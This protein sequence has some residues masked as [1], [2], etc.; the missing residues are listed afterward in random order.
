[1]KNISRWTA[2]VLARQ[3]YSDVQGAAAE[4]GA[5]REALAQAAEDQIADQNQEVGRDPRALPAGFQPPSLSFPLTGASN[6]T[7][8]A[9]QV[10]GQLE[11]A[12][13]QPKDEI[14]PKNQAGLDLRK[15]AQDSS[16]LFFCSLRRK[17]P[18]TASAEAAAGPTTTMAAWG[19]APGWPRIKN[20]PGSR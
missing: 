15:V 19:P 16:S 10:P 18:S 6:T 20:D 3:Y 5:G 14:E 8:K 4:V 12:R 11:P 2:T 7:S 13:Q 1:M 9:Q 17:Q